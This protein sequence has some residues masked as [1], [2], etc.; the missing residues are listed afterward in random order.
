[1]LPAF[2][3]ALTPEQ[4]RFASA[5]NGFLIKDATGAWL[6]GAQGF[7]VTWSGALLIERDGTYEFWAGAPAPGEDRP[8][9]DAA[10]CRQWRVVLS[11]GQRTLVTLSHHWAGEEEHAAAGLPLKRGAYELTAELV[12]P[13][14]EFRDDDE[15][16]PQHTGF[17]VKYRGPDSGGRRIEIPHRALFAVRKDQALGAGIEGLSPGAAAYLAGQYD[18][19]LRDIRRTYQRA[20]KALLFCH[21][22]GLSARREPH[23][24]SELGYLL[25]QPQLFAGTGYYRGGNGFTGHAAYFDFDFLPLRDDYHPP[26]PAADARADPSPQRVQA[27]F[28]WW[29]R[30]FDYAAG[31]ADVR[32]R[33]GRALWPLFDE[34]EQKQPAHPGYLLR[35]LAADSRHWQ[36]DLRYFQ[37]QDAPVYEVTSADLADERW[38]LRAWHADRWLRAMQDR[39]AVRDVTAARPDLWASDDP[40][41]ALPGETQTG[42]ASLLA[43]VTDGCLANG[44]P[45]RHED[46]KRIND[47]LRDRGRRALIAYLCHQDRVAAALAARHVRH[48]AWRPQRP[49]PARRRGR[50]AGE[51]EPDRGGDHRGPDVH[52]PEPTGPRAGLDGDPRVR[53]AVGQ[54]V[55]D[56]PDLG[57]GPAAGAV[58]GE[59]DRVGRAGQGPPH[60]GLPVPG[61]AV[62]LLDP[63]PGRPRRTGLVGGRRRD[64][65]ACAG[66]AAAAGAVRAQRAAAVCADDHQRWG[67]HPADHPRGAHHAGPSGVRRPADLARRGS[68]ARRARRDGGGQ[69][70]R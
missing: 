36:L 8:D 49:A 59:L 60:R 52:P 26:A 38:V 11:R 19:S 22:L 34:A 32:R 23:G 4:L 5:H 57:A 10:G 68:A 43:F 3:T 54:P 16:R 63:H 30:L 56:V 20:F 37:A 58:P 48:G 31:R 47:G 12:Q 51:G 64:P 6:G 35:H 21:R 33:S 67:H 15:V 9:A 46:L 69:R 70:D 7:T 45:H 13:A 62:A 1:M 14:P 17:Q 55:R 40:S 66:I 27:M 29:E 2:D 42:N 39:F 61:V 50:P 28:D 44:A 53:P 41:A 24:T 65:G 25:G 18:S